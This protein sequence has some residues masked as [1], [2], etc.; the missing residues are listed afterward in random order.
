MCVKRF[1]VFT[2]SKSSN[3]PFVNLT[4]HYKKACI[5]MR[6]ALLRIFASVYSQQRDCTVN[7]K[8]DWLM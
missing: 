4:S 3:M 8:C 5:V 1:L 6:Q 2:F 7:L